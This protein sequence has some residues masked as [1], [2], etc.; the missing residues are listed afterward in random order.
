[1]AIEIERKFLLKNDTWRTHVSS[2]LDIQ[3][4][5]FNRDD[6]YSVR[7]RIQDDSANLNI[8]SK[9]LGMQRH[10]YEYSIP[11]ADAQEMLNGLPDKIQKTRHL[12]K[13]RE[14]TWE[15]DEFYGDNSGLIVAEIELDNQDEAFIVPEWCS[16]EVT[17]DERFYNIAL[18]QKPYR[19]WVSHIDVWPDT[20]T[21]YALNP[22]GECVLEYLVS[23][24]KNGLGEIKN[25]E[26]T[27]RGLHTIRAKIGKD[28]KLG[29]VF[30][31][32]RVTNET[33]TPELNQS[34]PERDWILSR[35]LW[36]SGC[37]KNKNRLGDVDSMQRYIYIHGTPP[38][39]PLGKPLSHGCIRMRNEDVIEL[40]E[41]CF[42]GTTVMIHG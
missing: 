31:S 1:M 25:S 7:V 8:K 19:Y 27:P 32:R 40:F 28:V 22:L 17:N 10:E 37:E 29:S 26:C 21:L 2:S 16:T 13:H 18:V 30:S 4:A 24:A 38:T 3:Q 5:Y 39:E 23:T 15:I 42:I 14:H 35:I 20:Q 12:V 33:W 36:L 41:H 34:F 9:T 6:V 11:L